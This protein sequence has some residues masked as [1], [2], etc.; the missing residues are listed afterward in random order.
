MVL[1]CMLSAKR[2]S[3]VGQVDQTVMSRDFGR[4]AHAWCSQHASFV[5]QDRDS[6]SL[7]AREASRQIDSLARTAGLGG[8]GSWLHSSWDASGC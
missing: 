3:A 1:V 2:R 8:R 4:D 5:S 7:S 6:N